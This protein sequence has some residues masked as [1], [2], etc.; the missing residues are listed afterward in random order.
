MKKNKLLF[1]FLLLP[2]MV[3]SQITPD[4]SWS[5]NLGTWYGRSASAAISPDNQTIY[6]LNN[7]GGTSP[8][9]ARNTLDGSKKWTFDLDY[10]G[11]G[12]KTNGSV[13]VD[14]NGVVYATCANQVNNA[15][16]YAINP[17][18]TLKWK[19]DLGSKSYFSYVSPAI[20]KNGNI[21]VGTRGGDAGGTL[22]MLNAADGATISS[23]SVNTLGTIVVSQDNYCYVAAGND[24]VRIYDMNTIEEGVANSVGQYKVDP[25]TN[26]YTSGALAIDK[27][28]SVVGAAGSGK[29]FSITPNGTS[30]W[31]YPSSSNLSK[32]EQSGVAIGADRTYYVS[33]HENN[34]LYALTKDGT[35]KWEYATTNK[36]SSVPALDNLGQ[37]HIVDDSGIYYI[38]GD[39][40]TSAIELY[41]GDLPF[42]TES[43]SSPLISGDGAIYILAKAVEGGS[44][45]TRLYKITINGVDGPQL[46]SPWAMKGGDAQ[47]TGLQKDDSF[48]S[49]TREALA[50]DFKAYA[51]GG[52]IKIET[53]SNG[54][55]EVYNIY[56][57][58]ILKKYISTNETIIPLP[59][60]QVYLIKFEG[61][62]SKFIL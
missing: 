34:K 56:G 55:L 25:S 50:K 15:Q 14:S 33:G 10:T 20:M 36:L 5:V 28:G 17:D 1:I 26:Y 2:L 4:I 31:L 7:N 53:S 38:I 47:R 35:L 16:I 9:Y 8:L 12:N 19:K 13:A 62:T 61:K 52:A 18:G 3:G 45:N 57:Q 48:Y 37:I 23:N 46:N 11:S 21:I 22:V 30:K 27:D 59:V 29:V 58:C 51:V 49:S 54:Q 43:W 40:T 60:N 39:N 32:I 44:T 24:G 41:K 6:F 42:A